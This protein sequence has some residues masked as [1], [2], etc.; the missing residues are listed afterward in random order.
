[1]KPLI[2]DEEDDNKKYGYDANDMHNTA[3]LTT[4][5]SSTLKLI[6]VRQ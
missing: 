1:M 2:K 3:N 6:A 4:C 5:T